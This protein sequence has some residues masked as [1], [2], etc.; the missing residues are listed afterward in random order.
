MKKILTL[1]IIHQDSRV[2]LGMKKRGFGKG[3][4]NGFGGKV[5]TGESIEEAAR[6]EMQEEAGVTAGELE[7]VGIIEFEFEGDPT[8]LEVHIY[9]G[10]SILG[11]PT[12]SEEMKP[13]WF[14]VDAIPF[15]D[16]WPDDIYWFPFFLNR[17]KFKGKFLFGKMD[18]ILRNEL[19]EVEVLSAASDRG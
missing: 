5:E 7:K 13:E 18:A 8:L 17:R 1:C 4:W 19:S 10:E 9:R 6:R 11:T 14:N 15:A 3:R 2:L 12:E 16:M